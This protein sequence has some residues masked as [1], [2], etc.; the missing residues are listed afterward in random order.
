MCWAE[1][2]NKKGQR[3][4]MFGSVADQPPSF[5]FKIVPMSQPTAP[6][7]G[8]PTIHPTT[9][10]VPVPTRARTASCFF[11]STPPPGLIGATSNASSKNDSV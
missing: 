11:E 9:N 8:G 7:D 6:F 10:T 3:G 1:R 5:T 2:R 4:K